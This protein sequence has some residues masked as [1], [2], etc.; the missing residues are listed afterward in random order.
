VQA[1]KGLFVAVLLAG[2]S[3]AQV[4]PELAAC[5][6]ELRTVSTERDVVALQAQKIIERAQ[7]LDAQ[8]QDDKERARQFLLQLTLYCPKVRG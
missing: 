2:C 3:S 4:K 7:A 1:V 6:T 8:H 5:Q